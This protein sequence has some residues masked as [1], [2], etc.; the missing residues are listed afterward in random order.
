MLP[1]SLSLP[2][3]ALLA[4]LLLDVLCCSLICFALRFLRCFPSVGLP[5]LLP[6]FAV[7]PCVP[8]LLGCLPGLLLTVPGRSSPQVVLLERSQGPHDVTGSLPLHCAAQV[9]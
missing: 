4:R 6:F 9:R 8:S 7:L 1:A 2:S 5:A 3:L